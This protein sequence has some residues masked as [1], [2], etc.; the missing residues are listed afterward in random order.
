MPALLCTPLFDRQHHFGL[1][2]NTQS[3]RNPIDIIE[4][5]NDLCGDCN[6]LICEA[7]SV[8]CRNIVLCHAGR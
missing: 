7:R 3:I 4:V 2:I 8:E 5:S 6:L 1:G